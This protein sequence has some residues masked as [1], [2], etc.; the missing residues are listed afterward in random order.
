M[1]GGKAIPVKENSVGG[2]LFEMAFLC[3][4]SSL[5]IWNAGRNLLEII[6][7]A[8]KQQSVIAGI[9]M[10]FCVLCIIVMFVLV[11]FLAIIQ[12]CIELGRRLSAWRKGI[13]YGQE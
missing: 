3:G 11:P 9:L 2:L 5:I 12:R 8:F 1:P 7:D 4:F 13:S 10:G 6:Q